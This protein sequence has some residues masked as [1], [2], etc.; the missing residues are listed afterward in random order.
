MN[1]VERGPFPT[2]VLNPN[3]SEAGYKP[4]QRSYRK[5]KLNYSVIIFPGDFGRGDFIREPGDI[6]YSMTLAAC[7]I[8]PIIECR[9]IC[10]WKGLEKD[11]VSSR[12]SQP[13]DE[14][15]GLKIFYVAR[16][17]NKNTFYMFVKWIEYWIGI[18]M[19]LTR[20]RN[21]LTV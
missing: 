14:S 17:R 15:L 2:R 3:A 13:L 11:S 10:P 21:S 4:K 19:S 1:A 20:F 16:N 8:Y 12:V 9:I 5:T 6:I 18:A 7:V